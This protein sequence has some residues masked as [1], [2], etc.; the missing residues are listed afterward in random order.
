MFEWALAQRGRYC[1]EVPNERPFP[2]LIYPLV[3]T[4]LEFQSRRVLARAAIAPPFGY[5]VVGR[6]VTE[7]GYRD[8]MWYAPPV[9]ASLWRLCE[10]LY[11]ALTGVLGWLYGR[12]V[13][14]AVGE[15]PYYRDLQWW[16]T[17]P[18]VAGVKRPV[19]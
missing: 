5:D 4:R 7:S 18:T 15:A 1:V 12:G 3:A 13:L 8:A 14:W 16:W 2:R 9:E 11:R 19:I 6:V 10:Q 17:R